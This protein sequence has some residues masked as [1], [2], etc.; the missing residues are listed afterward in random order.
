MID[1][2]PAE[3]V[4]C[5]GEYQPIFAK[6]PKVEFNEG[7]PDVRQFDGKEATLLII[8][9]L[10]NET[11]ESMSAIFTKVSRHRNVSVVYI[12]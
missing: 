5:Y 11:N 4:C 7:L 12:T 3:I 10:M 8:D 6:Y 9:D 1:P 2:S